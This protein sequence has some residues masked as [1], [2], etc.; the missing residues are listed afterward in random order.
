MDFQ[1][2]L[3][4]ITEHVDFGDVRPCGV[5]KCAKFSPESSLLGQSGSRVIALLFL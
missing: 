3:A 5:I 1:L 2:V 4:V